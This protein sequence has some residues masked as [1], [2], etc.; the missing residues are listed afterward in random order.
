[1]GNLPVISFDGSRNS[2]LVRSGNGL[3]NKA[4]YN[5]DEE[6][7]SVF[8]VEEPFLS[9]ENLSSIASS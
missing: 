4:G 5:G 8:G 9:A 1:M 6:L 2:N 7:G 3:S